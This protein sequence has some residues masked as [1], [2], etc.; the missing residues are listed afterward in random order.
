MCWVFTVTLVTLGPTSPSTRSSVPSAS[1]A[2]TS[3]ASS[4]R[5]AVAWHLSAP[6]SYVRNFTDV[7]DKIIR[8]ASEARTTHSTA[9]MH[10]L[11]EYRAGITVL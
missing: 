10:M 2:S 1:A 11:T 8:R 6:R 9:H 5:C 3:R 4:L 7:D